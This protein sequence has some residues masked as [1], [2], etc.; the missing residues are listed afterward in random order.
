VLAGASPHAQFRPV[1][2]N[3]AAGVLITLRGR[4]A[5]VMAFTVTGGRIAAVDGITDPRRLRD[6]VRSGRAVPL[7]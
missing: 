2:V 4:A 5:A 1:L 3:G 6:L 7:G